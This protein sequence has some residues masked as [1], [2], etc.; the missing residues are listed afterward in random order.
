MNRLNDIFSALS[1]PTRRAILAQLARGSASVAD[2][3]RPFN[4][5]VQAV[6][7]HVRVLERAGLVSRERDAQRRLSRLELA[8]LKE[9]DEWLAAYRV[10]WTKHLDRLEAHL[11]QRRKLKP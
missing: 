1:D 11:D 8:P 9:L 3:A 4:M 2:L 5:T 6:S 10:L 7:K